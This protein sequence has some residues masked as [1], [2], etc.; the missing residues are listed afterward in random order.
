MGRDGRLAGAVGQA[1]RSTRACRATRIGVHVAPP[2]CAE[3]HGSRSMSLDPIVRDMDGRGDRT[4]R[5]RGRHGRLHGFPCR[6]GA[7]RHA[8]AGVSAL[9]SVARIQVQEGVAGA[10][11]TCTLP[12]PPPPPDPSGDTTLV[13]F[14]LE[15][16]ADMAHAVPVPAH[17][18]P[19]APAAPPMSGAAP[20]AAGVSLVEVPLVPGF[21]FVES[22]RDEPSRCLGRQRKHP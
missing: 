19:V 1:G 14:P 8:P 17:K 20:P 13:W 9:K 4:T 22:P 2:A 21:E 7:T 12:P 15:P 16:A 5:S 11:M 18:P 3:R 6:T 10:E